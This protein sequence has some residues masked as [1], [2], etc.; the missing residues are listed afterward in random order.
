MFVTDQYSEA[1][2]KVGQRERRAATSQIRVTPNRQV[3][4]FF[5][6]FKVENTIRTKYLK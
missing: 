6:I 1:S 4:L 5:L 2:I 3:E